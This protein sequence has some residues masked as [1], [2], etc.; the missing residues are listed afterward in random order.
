VMGMLV[1]AVIWWL[2]QRPTSRWRSWPSGCHV[3]FV[4]QD[5][6][7]RRGIVLDPVVELEPF[8]PE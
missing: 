2:D 7:T 1:A 6:V 5:A 3:M 8:V 4:L